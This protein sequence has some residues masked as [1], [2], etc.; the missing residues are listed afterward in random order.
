MDVLVLGIQYSTAILS[1]LFVVFVLHQKHSR[2]CT[3][4]LLFSIAVFLNELSYL[5]EIRSTDIKEAL[6][7]VRFEYIS[8]SVAVIAA[9]F[10]ACELFNVKIRE[11]LRLI[12]VSA[13]CTTCIFVFTN[14]LHHLHYRTY[15][16]EVRENFAVLHMEI[17]IVYVLHTVITLISMAVCI[18]VIAV[19]WIQDTKRKEEFHKYLFLIIAAALPLLC[20]SVRFAEPVRD[21]DLIPFGL[22]CTDCCFLLIIHF[23]RLFDV[24]ENAKNEILETMEEGI[25]VCDEE[26]N[27]VYTNARLREIFQMSRLKKISEVMRMLV[28]TED[29]DFCIEDRY[30][31]V[32]ESEVYE[33]NS[34]KGKMLCFIDITQSKEKERQLKELHDTA[35]AA[36]NAKSSFLANMSHEIRT[37]I[38]AILGM[39]ELILREARELNILEYAENIKA[40]SRTLL[41]LI[42]DLLDFSKIESGKMEIR[43][44]EYNIV[45]LLRDVASVYSMKA[46]EKGLDFR[47]NIAEDIPAVLFGDELRIKQIFN[48]IL[49][50]AVK[51]TERGAIWLNAEWNLLAEKQAEIVVSV[52]D[53]GIGIRKEDLEVIFEKFKRLDA[54]RTGRIEGIGLGMS[55]TAQLLEIMHGSIAVESE[56]GIGSEFK[57]RIPQKI[58]NATAAGNYD[59]PLEAEKKEA[60]HITF[61]APEAKVL[62]VDDNLMNRIIIKGL[63]KRTLLQVDEAGS[64]LEC[65]RKTESTHYDI[66]LLDHMMPEM[67]GIETLQRLKQQD[68][69]CKDSVVIMLTA[70]AVAGAREF[71]LNSGFDD[72]LSKP[73]SGNLLESML[74]KYLPEELVLKR[75]IRSD[76]Y[77]VRNVPQEDIR[78]EDVKEI[79]ALEHIDMTGSLERLGGD[80]EMYKDAARLFS[81]LREERMR[82]LHEYI[83]TEDA[84]SYAIM[85]HAI[86]GEAKLLGVPIL[87][88]IAYEQEKMGKEG[89][90]SFLLDKFGLL[91]AEYQKTADYFERVFGR[92]EKEGG[93]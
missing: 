47:V 73:V 34:V 79:L 24:A 5:F 17:G 57:V 70:N 8:Q 33:K 46:E 32:V 37:P 12:Y 67:D 62:V 56:Y 82:K 18:G 93:D 61:T 75:E 66:I 76:E 60:P 3:Y 55:I 59:F 4:L 36:N 20:W 42:N 54:K 13:F 10:F 80:E 30:Y 64:G 45:R 28:P 51:Y 50:N 87:A 83:Q 63:L 31:S 29:G 90:L 77:G 16:L 11:W 25:L 38:N 72:Y 23:F 81:S 43:E 74:I 85:A 71:Y 9:L 27:I 21:Y 88:D 65:L 19:A 86:K 53:S 68:G 52:R 15:F 14:P 35:L 84:F 6:M 92:A 91:S 40:E 49:S 69:A 58:I 2:L 78:P 22:F 89:N 44:E 48:N 7:A 26:G 39:D 41:S 1:L